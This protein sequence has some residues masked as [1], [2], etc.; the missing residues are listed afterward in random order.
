LGGDDMSVLAR[1]FFT[2]ADAG[3]RDRFLAECLP[4]YTQSKTPIGANVDFEPDVL[5][6]FF[7][8]R[9]DAHRFDFRAGLAGVTVPTLIIGG[10]SDPVVPPEAVRELAASFPASVVRLQIFEQCGHGPARDRPVEALAAIR[11]F[12]RQI[13]ES[14]TAATS[15]LA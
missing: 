11:A 14:D 9:G 13:A 8:G 2:G 4:L 10:D 6:H 5:D 7:S 3:H 1:S 12:V 15:G